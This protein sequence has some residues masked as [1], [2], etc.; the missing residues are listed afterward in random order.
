MKGAIVSS[1]DLESQPSILGQATF[2]VIPTT[3]TFGPSVLCFFEG[4][5]MSV[6]AI[7][8]DLEARVKAGGGRNRRKNNI[9]MLTSL[10][11]GQVCNKYVYMR[12]FIIKSV[13]TYS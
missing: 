8:I 5:G 9:Y 2:T 3:R 1:N 4:R 12:K 11:Q 7:R 13:S 6:A 10:A